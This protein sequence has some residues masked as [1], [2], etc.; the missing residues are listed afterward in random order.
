MIS[1]AMSYLRSQP[2]IIKIQI[3]L[4]FLVLAYTGCSGKDVVK[5]MFDFSLEVQAANPGVYW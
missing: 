2:P 4:T 1:V 3:G 5:R